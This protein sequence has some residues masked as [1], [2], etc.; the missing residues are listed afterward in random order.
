VSSPEVFAYLD[1]DERP[2]E[3]VAQIV[4]AEMLA[5]A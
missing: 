3:E 5:H 4:G 2:V 1:G